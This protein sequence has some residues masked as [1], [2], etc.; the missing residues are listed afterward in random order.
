MLERLV[1]LLVLGE[2]VIERLNIAGAPRPNRVPVLDRQ[3]MVQP[4][5]E[6]PERKDLP[7][8]RLAIEKCEGV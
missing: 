7:D 3:R 1:E 4:L 6:R 5:P 2:H 8:V